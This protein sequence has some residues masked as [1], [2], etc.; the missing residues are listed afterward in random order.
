[1]PEFCRIW[2]LNFGLITKPLYHAMKGPEEILKWARNLEIVT[3][4]FKTKRGSHN[5]LQSPPKRTRRNNPG[6]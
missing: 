3:C 5:S 2:I 6:K 4:S 1:M